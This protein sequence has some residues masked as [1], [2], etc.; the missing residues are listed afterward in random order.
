MNLRKFLGFK[1]KVGDKVKGYSDYGVQYEGTVIQVENSKE[2]PGAYVKGKF[3]IST[4]WKGT[5]EEKN[6]S[7]FVPQ[8][9]L[10]HM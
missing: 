5:I 3:I 8:G 4:L 2:I 6:D 7:F 10:R 9:R 1:L